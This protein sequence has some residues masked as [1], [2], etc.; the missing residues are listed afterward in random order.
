MEMKI[1]PIVDQKYQELFDLCENHNKN[2][3]LNPKDV[4][5]WLGKDVQWLLN[6]TYA[7]AVPFAFGTNKMLGRGNSCFHVLPLF[8]FAT[9]GILFRP[10]ADQEKIRDLVEARTA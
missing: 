5:R 8:A 7:G 6:T 2:G 4:A 10:V 9:Q 3:L 1:P